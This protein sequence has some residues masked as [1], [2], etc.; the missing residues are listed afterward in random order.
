MKIASVFGQLLLSV[1]EKLKRLASLLG[2]M[3]TGED[4]TL[5]AV[6][7]KVDSPVLIWDVV[8]G[9]YHRDEF[10]DDELID[11]GVDD[12]LEYFLVVKLQEDG[13][14]GIV[15]FWVETADDAYDIVEHFKTNIEPLEI[16]T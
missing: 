4:D 13:A 10:D 16:T 11:I 1:S 12:N 6:T 15:N 3:G 5:P 9:P 2:T 8:D 7:T 14:V